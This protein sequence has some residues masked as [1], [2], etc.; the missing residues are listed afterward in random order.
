VFLLVVI[1]AVYFGFTK[2]I[3]FKHGFRLKRAVRPARSTSNRSP[4]VRIGRCQR[5]QGDGHPA[6][7]LDRAGEDGNRIARACR[8][9]PMRPVK[10]R[11]RIFLEGNWFVELQPGSPSTNTLSSGATLPSHAVVRIR[12]NSTRCSTR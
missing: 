12:C 1:V 6:P 7:G 3:P 2:R 10:I 8:C 5:G 4:P 11:P 9:I